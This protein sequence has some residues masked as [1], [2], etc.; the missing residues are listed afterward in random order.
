MG[1]IGIVGSS[2]FIGSNLL[3][4]FPNAFEIS[5]EILERGCDAE[6]EM[7][8]IAAPNADKWKINQ[9]P[10]DD[11]T[12]IDRFAER[13]NLLKSHH[14]ILFSTVDVYPMEEIVDEQSKTITGLNY[15][16]NRAH[17]E[18][19]LSGI[20]ANLQIRRI[21][22]L[23][24]QGMKKNVIFDALH[25][26]FDQLRNYSPF[27]THQYLSVSKSIQIALD[28]KF[29]NTTIVNVV[30]PPI[31]LEDLLPQCRPYFNADR[32]KISYDIRTQHNNNENY[33]SRSEDV[34][35]DVQKFLRANAVV[36][37]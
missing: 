10:L 24:G 8:L 9:N 21:G 3:Q 4:N 25:N 7:L 12:E 30:G 31:K 6:F 26:S 35:A 13:L 17:F 33:F 22:G 36:W 37:P 19:L 32:P 28:Q 11:R 20:F 14:C 2:G 27:S 23:F 15:G 29:Q 18:S 5:R 16:S 34:I 1:V